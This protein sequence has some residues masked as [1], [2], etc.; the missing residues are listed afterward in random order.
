MKYLI[1]CN[2]NDRFYTGKLVRDSITERVFAGSDVNL[3]RL[4][5]DF[6][7]TLLYGGILANF[8]SFNVTLMDSVQTYVHRFLNPAEPS[9]FR[10]AVARHYNLVGTIDYKQP[11]G[12]QTGLYDFDM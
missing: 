6:S 9:D 7:P 12:L 2:Y 4:P 1:E 8:S 5:N 10:V 3:W 11:L